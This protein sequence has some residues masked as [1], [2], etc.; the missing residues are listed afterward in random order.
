MAHRY[1]TQEIYGDKAV[2]TG[3]DAVHLSRVL[4]LKIGE[5]LV[6]FDGTGMDYM[7]KTSH[8]TESEI[9]LDIITKEKNVSEPSIGVTLYVGYP[10]GDKLEWII[11]K[12]VEIGVV[13]IVPFFSKFCVVT[14]K[15]EEQKN[16]RYNKIVYEAVKQSGRGIIPQ[17][18]MPI[19][20]KEML[21]EQDEFDLSLFCY[22]AQQGSRSLLSQLENK[23]S[24]SIITG[25]EGG[26]DTNEVILAQEKCN[27]ISLGKRI[28]RCETAPLV[29]A[30]A[31][32]VLTG[33]IE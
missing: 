10:K 20:F 15:K 3:K 29:A 33:N 28:L 6:L 23:K 4:R 25:S 30:T 2:I 32:M 12:S 22:E 9:I 26:F 8:I 1:Y 13:R 24:I 16:I 27:V 11:Q 5:E 21:A 14:P 17:V 31:V 7:A 19:T 18:S